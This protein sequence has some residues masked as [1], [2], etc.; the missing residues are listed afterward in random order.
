MPKIR[1]GK[2]R[3]DRANGAV[4]RNESNKAARNAWLKTNRDSGLQSH[5]KEP[6]PE[7]S[8]GGKGNSSN[9]IKIREGKKTNCR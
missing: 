9:P 2:T 4:S 7:F 1:V 8:I 6:F 5:Q 3:R